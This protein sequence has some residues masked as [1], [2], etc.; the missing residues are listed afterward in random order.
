VNRANYDE[1][2][3]APDGRDGTPSLALSRPEGMATPSH[4]SEA[5]RPRAAHRY[6]ATRG[7][8]R[9]MRD[10]ARASASDDCAAGAMNRCRVCGASLET[11][12]PGVRGLSLQRG[13]LSGGAV[14]IVQVGEATLDARLPLAPVFGANRGTPR[15]GWETGEEDGGPRSPGREARRPAGLIG[16]RGLLPEATRRLHG[17]LAAIVSRRHEPLPGV[18]ASLRGPAPARAHLLG[19]MPVSKLRTR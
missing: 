6:S 17:E 4:G 12:P 9:R 1:S 18:G 11:A 13:P 10:P 15:E 2:E 16:A 3:G 14:Q 8:G 19:R 7:M 5:A